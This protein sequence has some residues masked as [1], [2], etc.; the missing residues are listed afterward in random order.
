MTNRSREYLTLLYSLPDLQY[1]G[2]C[3]V[4]VSDSQSGLGRRRVQ[5]AL[6][7]RRLGRPKG[8]RLKADPVRKGTRLLGDKRPDQL[9]LPFCLWTR[10]AVVCCWR[11]NA[12]CRSRCGPPGSI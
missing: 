2:G 1:A 6:A 8:S 10:E 3:T 4:I 11:E 5:A 12:G 9:K 7:P